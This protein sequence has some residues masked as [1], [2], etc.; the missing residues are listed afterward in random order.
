M[1]DHLISELESRYDTT[2]SQIIGEF[3][4]VIAPKY[5]QSPPKKNSTPTRSLIF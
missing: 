3:F 1:L 5:N 4:T 2:T